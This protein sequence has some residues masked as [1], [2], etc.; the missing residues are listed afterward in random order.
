MYDDACEA[1]ADLGDFEFER[2]FL[3]REL[4]AEAAAD[5]GR[6]FYTRRD[7]WRIIIRNAWQTGEPGVVFIDR[8]NEHNPTPHIGRMEATN[9]CGEAH[10]A[11][12]VTVCRPVAGV[13][14]AGP[15]ALLTGEPGVY[16][17][18]YTPPD[19]SPPLT[20]TW[21]GGAAGPTA[22]YSWTAPGVY[23]V[24]VTATPPRLADVFCALEASY[25]GIRFRVIDAAG[26]PG[27]MLEQALQ[28]LRRLE[29]GLLKY[30]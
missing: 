27:A 24:T 26:S 15:A 10:A 1:A 9:P 4:P 30:L 28:H 12:T 20:I 19:A 11:Y 5:S 21:S 29:H 8:I 7:L 13:A 14:I 17:A 22:A 18:T 6:A 23:T 25:P 16:T 2:K 3:L